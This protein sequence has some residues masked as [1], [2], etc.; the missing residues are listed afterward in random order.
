MGGR[1]S[2][3]LENP[4][5]Y[6]LRKMFHKMYYHFRPDYWYWIV[7]ILGRKLMIAITALMFAKN[8]A[9]QARR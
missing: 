1:G 4:N 9:F 3:R 6:G 5:C 8:P 7:V 2:T